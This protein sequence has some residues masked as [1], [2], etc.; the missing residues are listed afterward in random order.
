[1]LLAEGVNAD[2][3]AASARMAAATF[4][5]QGEQNLAIV[6]NCVLSPNT[7]RRQLDIIV[8]ITMSR[9]AT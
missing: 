8:S 6:T 1:M 7:V 5:I 2:A 4:I 3:E 9:T